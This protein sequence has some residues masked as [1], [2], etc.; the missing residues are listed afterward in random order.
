MDDE[1]VHGHGAH[2]D[3][4]EDVGEEPEQN[5][6]SIPT[7]LRAVVAAARDHGSRVLLEG[8]DPQLLSDLLREAGLVSMQHVCKEVAAKHRKRYSDDE[9]GDYSARADDSVSYLYAVLDAPLHF[10]G[11][12]GWQA[13]GRGS[14]RQ[15][16]DQ[17]D[18]KEGKTTARESA[19]VVVL[20]QAL[21]SL[22][23]SHL[24][25][26]LPLQRQTSAALELMR[27]CL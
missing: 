18:T 8:V 21:R 19:C 10:N 7:L 26:D 1:G 20:G 4:T 3:P 5:A 17:G 16:R 2:T 14:Q 9:L 23:A 11:E 15:R 22:C 6:G 27:R 12:Q 13:S 25:E 24:T